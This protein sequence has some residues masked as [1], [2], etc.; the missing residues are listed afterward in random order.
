MYFCKA[1][2]IANNLKEQVRPIGRSCLKN[3]YRSLQNENANDHAYKKLCTAQSE[4]LLMLERCM[5][6]GLGVSESTYF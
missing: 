6:F 3:T 2:T 1:L 4:S 5:G